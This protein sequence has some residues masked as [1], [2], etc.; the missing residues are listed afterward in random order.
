[1]KMFYKSRPAVM[2]DCTM[3]SVD[4]VNDPVLVGCIASTGIWREV[5]CFK[6]TWELRVFGKLSE[7]TTWAISEY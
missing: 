1:M 2:V 4:F 3:W 5:F 7:A 6:F